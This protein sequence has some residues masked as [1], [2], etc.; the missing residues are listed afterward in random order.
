MSSLTE[1]PTARW[2]C[3]LACWCYRSTAPPSSARRSRERAGFWAPEGEVA[4]GAVH[5]EPY[6]DRSSRN[7]GRHRS[8]LGRTDVPLAAACTA[9]AVPHRPARRARGAAALAATDP[10]GSRLLHQRG[11]DDGGPDPTGEFAAAPAA[12]RR[13]CAAAWDHPQPW[14][15]WRGG[16]RGPLACA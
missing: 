5:K 12:P 14:P 13:R 16:V 2:T 3:P 9:P 6:R 8:G 11:V 7:H 10:R 15:L 1:T 4:P